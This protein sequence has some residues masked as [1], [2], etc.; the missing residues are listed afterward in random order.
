MQLKSLRCPNCSGS[1]RQI[2]DGK[3]VCESCGTSFVP[4]L[5]PE[6]V[7]AERIKAEAEVKKAR[8][9]A[10]SNMTSDVQRKARMARARGNVAIV[11]IL[12]FV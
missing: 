2:G 3:Y 11:M 4:D 5:D 9:Q 12:A 10:A 6:D 1:V 8:I 7:E